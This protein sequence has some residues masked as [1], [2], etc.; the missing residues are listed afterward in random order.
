MAQK[1]SKNPRRN[2]PGNPADREVIGT[3]DQRAVEMVRETD[4]LTADVGPF[5]DSFMNDLS[6]L[7]ALPAIDLTTPES[8]QAALEVLNQT[9]EQIQAHLK[10]AQALKRVLS[11][12]R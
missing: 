2:N 10:T 6:N 3:F 5:L 12:S 8:A 4:S 9:Q 11:S 1:K 7:E